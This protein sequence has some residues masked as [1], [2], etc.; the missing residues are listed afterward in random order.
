MK[1]MILTEGQRAMRNA[2]GGTRGRRLQDRAAPGLQ[3][4]RHPVTVIATP[5]GGSHI[6]VN[7]NYS[8]ARLLSMNH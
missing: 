6:R 1:N 3:R 4:A 7:G 5:S 2:E 8:S